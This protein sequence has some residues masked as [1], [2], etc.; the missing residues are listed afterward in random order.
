MNYL[1]EL[2]GMNNNS[3]VVYRLFK[4]LELW[5]IFRQVHGEIKK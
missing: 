4:V 1:V 5:V 2:A 3:L